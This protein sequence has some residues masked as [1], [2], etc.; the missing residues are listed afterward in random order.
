MTPTE[1]HRETAAAVATK[2]IGGCM[3]E[4]AENWTAQ[5]DWATEVI[6]TALAKAER[7]GMKHAAEIALA[8]THRSIEEMASVGSDAYWQGSAS[9]A[10]CIRNSILSEA[11][12]G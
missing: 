11:G 1:K 4:T 2:A 12:E 6:A 5:K 8:R 10:E 9:S 7:E 3:F